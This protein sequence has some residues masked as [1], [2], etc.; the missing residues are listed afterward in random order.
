MFSNM[1]QKKHSYFIHQQF[2]QEEK[3]SEEKKHKEYFNT[4]MEQKNLTLE[5]KKDIYINLS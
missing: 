1:E 3:N 2:K 4:E 5:E